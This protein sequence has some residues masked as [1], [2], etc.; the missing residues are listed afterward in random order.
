MKKVSIN[1]IVLVL[2]FSQIITTGLLAQIGKGNYKFTKV[3][4]IKSTSVKDQNKS[5]TCWSFAAISFIESELFRMGKGEYDLSEMYTVRH[6]YLSKA[7][8]YVRLHGHTI[9]GAGGQAHDVTN[10]IK[11]F[12]IVPENIYPGL[13]YGEEQHF[14]GELDGV[15]KGIV[16]A[17][18]NNKDKKITP[19]WKNSFIATL[20]A[21]LGTLPEN[22]E[23][24]GKT[25]TPK[26]FAVDHLEF[27][28]DD[29]IELTSYSH[30]PY[31]EKFILEIP[32]NW[33]NDLYYNVTLDDMMNIIDNAFN[34]GFSVCWDGDISG[35][36]SRRN[37]YAKLPDESK[38][39]T[40]EMRQKA[41]DNYTSTDD[42]LMHLTG[43][44]KDQ[45]GT[46]FYI[47]KNS[48]NTDN[49]YDGYWYM[50]ESFLRMNTVAIMIHKD[51]LPK[52]IRKKLGL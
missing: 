44:A 43:I 47:T 30:H 20:D 8:N 4:E 37:G 48:W 45:H 6:A 27:N 32:D 35:D 7:W 10:A 9:F 12:G 34:E 26:S 40:M 18:V 39:V 46:K 28:V 42:H 50:S 15:L 21:Y 31:Y 11:E 24:N 1:I 51:A 38:K 33:S 17:V 16:K 49:S 23:F 14:H 29:Y 13:N 25:Y 36:F 5:G 3:K 2:L 41:F 19:V 52:D 22:F